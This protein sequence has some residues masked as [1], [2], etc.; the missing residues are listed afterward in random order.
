MKVKQF[1]LPVAK[2]SVKPFYCLP[3]ILLEKFVQVDLIIE[4]LKR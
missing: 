2:N 4:H 3:K 1:L